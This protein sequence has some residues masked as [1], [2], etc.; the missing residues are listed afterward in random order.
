M[1][2]YTMERS[3]FNGATANKVVDIAAS[4]LRILDLRPDYNSFVLYP[5]A[6]K[7]R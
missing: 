4:H 5:I 1:L 3:L 6:K 7:S 2:K